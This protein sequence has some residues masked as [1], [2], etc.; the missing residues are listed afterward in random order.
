MVRM[1]GIRHFSMFCGPLTHRSRSSIKHAHSTPSGTTIPRGLSSLPICETS[2]IMSNT[3]VVNALYSEPRSSLLAAQAEAVGGSCCA[4]KIAS[5]PVPKG[6]GAT[7]AVCACKEG[8]D[9][10][11]GPP[12]DDNHCKCARP[13]ACSNC[14][15]PRG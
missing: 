3:V 9:N 8:A 15:C 10:G 11:F 14:T 12:A 2:N 5:F 7:E 13:C 6:A 1:D 4:H